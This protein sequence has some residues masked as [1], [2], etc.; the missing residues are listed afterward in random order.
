MKAPTI[1]MTA[2]QA[3]QIAAEAIFPNSTYEPE[4]V[5]P[6]I[7]LSNQSSNKTSKAFHSVETGYALFIG[8]N[9]YRSMSNLKGCVNDVK[10]FRDKLLSFGWNPDRI[11][12]MLDN[13]ATKS[14]IIS[15]IQ[16][17]V[18]HCSDKDSLWFH[19]SGH[20]SWTLTNDGQGWECCICCHDCSL[21]DWDNGI[22][23][24]TEFISA[25]ERPSGNLSVI[26]DSCFSGG[27]TPYY[28]AQKRLPAVVYDILYRSIP[29]GKYSA[30]LRAIPGP[31]WL[32]K[33]QA[34]ERMKLSRGEFKKLIINGSLQTRKIL[35]GH[36]YVRV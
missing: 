28:P 26:L 12:I 17:L 13:Q 36:E 34:R 10:N 2:C 21:D 24:R 5:R 33:P 18:S 19:F 20:G 3:T 1:F 23:T 6:V 14:G 29:E 27:V 7:D 31:E 16:W 22:I 4:P 9:Y 25:L 35:N 11:M 8:I 15:G 32:T 30:N